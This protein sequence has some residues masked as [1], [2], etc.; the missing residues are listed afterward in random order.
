MKDKLIRLLVC[1]AFAKAILSCQPSNSVEAE[2]AAIPVDVELIP[3]HKIFAEAEVEDL[4]QLKKDYPVFISTRVP[5]SVWMAKMTGK[6]SIQNILEAAVQNAEFDYT[7]IESEVEDVMKHV[8]YYFPDFQSTDI[9]TVISEVNYRQQIIPTK[10]Q[11]IISI[12]TYLGKDHELYQGIS[13]YQR[14]QLNREQLPADVAMEYARLFV[15]P[16]M[17]RTFLGSM[18]YF[19]KI[20][21]LQ[22]LFVP[23]A[24]GYHIFDYPPA[25]FDYT[26]ENE[27]QMWRY[28]IDKEMLYDTDSRLIPRFIAPAPFSKFYLEID[29]QTP[30]GV[31]R[32]MGYRIVESFMQNNP[33]D[34]ETMIS[35]D[36]ES[37]FNKS[38]YKPLQ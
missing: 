30:G 11:L 22:S 32:Y 13:N 26:V 31:G 24:A 15:P 21:Y 23:E 19:G 3:F 7:A 27:S 8:K 12:D 29:Q 33:V 20:H 36:A 1:I 17:D 9:Y 5:D 38:K 16:T 10:D 6:D 28:F 18:V 2:I 34:L 25:K 14:N 4:E 37:L 35:L